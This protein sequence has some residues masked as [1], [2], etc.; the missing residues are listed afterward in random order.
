MCVSW[1]LWSLTMW[2]SGNASERSSGVEFCFVKC[3]AIH[4]CLM[5]LFAYQCYQC[6]TSSHDDHHII[7]LFHFPDEIFHPILL[8]CLQH[9]CL[10]PTSKWI[11]TQM[12]HHG[13]L[14]ANIYI[15]YKTLYMFH[16]NST[17]EHAKARI[18][19]NIPSS[20][21]ILF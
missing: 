1:I 17:F 15:F 2:C 8:F 14:K 6:P 7:I 10:Q 3:N 20:W 16:F 19:N 12:F 9:A 4:T 18:Q 11:V 13:L 5:S 21:K